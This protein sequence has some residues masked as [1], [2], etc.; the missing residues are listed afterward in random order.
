M[1]YG[2]PYELFWHLNPC[3]LQPFKEA[4]EKKIQQEDYNAWIQGAYIEAAIGSALSKKVKYPEK[5]FSQVS[6]VKKE[7][8]PE[9]QFLLWIDNFNKRFEEK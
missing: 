1:L 6:S 2:V 4:Y 8:S 3:K 7:I 9:E 5:P